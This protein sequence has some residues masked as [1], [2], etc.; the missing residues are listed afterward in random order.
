MA[1]TI[2]IAILALVIAVAITATTSAMD[3]EST[4][5]SKTNNGDYGPAQ[6]RQKLLSSYAT[7]PPLSSSSSSDQYKKAE[8]TMEKSYLLVDYE[9]R[10]RTYN[11]FLV[12]GQIKQAYGDV[13]KESDRFVKMADLNQSISLPNELMCTELSSKQSQLKELKNENPR[14]NDFFRKAA[15]LQKE[16]ERLA[17]LVEESYNE[18]TI[19]TD[20]YHVCQVA[21]KECMQYNKYDEGLEWE[22]LNNAL[23]KIGVKTYL[24]GLSDKRKMERLFDR[25]QKAATRNEP[26]A[27]NDN[28]SCSTITGT[29]QASV[30]NAESTVSQILDLDGNVVNINDEMER[31]VASKRSGNTVQRKLPARI[32]RKRSLRVSEGKYMKQEAYVCLIRTPW[33]GI[34][35]NK[36][37]NTK[38]CF[39]GKNKEGHGLVLVNDRLFCN[40]CNVPVVKVAQHLVTVNH[41]KAYESRKLRN[42]NRND[43]N[44]AVYN[45]NS[46]SIATADSRE[47]NEN[48]LRGKTLTTEEMVYRS[49]VL[50]TALIANMTMGQLQ[51]F[52]PALDAKGDTNPNI[53]HSSN[54][55]S[56]HLAQVLKKEKELIRNEI[57]ES[58]DEFAVTIDGSP[59]GDDAEA[60][61]LRLVNKNTKKVKDFIISIKLHK[62]K[63]NGLAIANNAITELRDYGITQFRGMVYISMDRAGNNG[64]ALKCL[65]EKNI[66]DPTFGPCHSHTINLPGKEFNETCKL[67][68]LFRKYWNKSICTRGNLCKEMKKYLG[69]FP[70]ISSGVR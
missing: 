52:K 32:N 47:R 63:L 16:I 33:S 37:L 34:R 2:A 18:I 24:D 28:T 58:Y 40:L 11:Q 41:Q 68:N 3:K 26:T 27:T 64:V 12:D 30:D 70:V 1:S 13:L 29:V 67:M 38:Q 59:I 50:R 21:M 31:G 9:K 5:K 51:L 39:N 25:S 65:K 14:P 7:F 54:L 61:S 19:A 35:F 56:D 45:N 15:S 48:N 4:I 23:I 69:K 8:S 17:P 62:K 44:P 60:I 66:A 6:K 10:I 36:A 43:L 55:I 46:V 53:G 22:E 49:H 57:N 42:A 20:A